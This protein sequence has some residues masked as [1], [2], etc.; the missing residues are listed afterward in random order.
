[1]RP[2]PA[3]WPSRA[4]PAS[5][6]PTSACASSTPAA[7]SSPTPTTTAEVGGPYFGAFSAD[8]AVDVA[9]ETEAC[10]QI[11][12]QSARDGLDVNVVQI[13]VTLLP[14]LVP[15]LPADFPA[16]LLYPGAT[17]VSDSRS[18]NDEGETFVTAHLAVD[19]GTAAILAFYERAFAALDGPR[20][21]LRRLHGA[22][23]HPRRLPRPAGRLLRRPSHHPRRRRPRRR[24]PR[25][26][27]DQPESARRV[28]RA[29]GED[30]GGPTSIAGSMLGR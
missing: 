24:H 1:M 11:F 19:A 15:A 14:T 27:D 16:A 26:G 7:P 18:S 3:R 6:R 4:S 12:E 30:R 21:G 20:P 9:E 10:V 25:R 13:G 5:S 22:Q 2:S 23:R 29:D 17:V 8:I 28:G